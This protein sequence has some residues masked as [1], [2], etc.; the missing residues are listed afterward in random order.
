MWRKLPGHEHQPITTC[1]TMAM[2]SL[3]DGCYVAPCSI[4]SFAAASQ[5][6]FAAMSRHVLFLFHSRFVVG[7]GARGINVKMHDWKPRGDD[8][9]GTKG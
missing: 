3:V 8:T 9:K 6:P 1:K 5:G 4:V 2:S 7:S